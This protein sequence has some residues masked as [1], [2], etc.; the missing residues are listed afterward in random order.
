MN[1]SQRHIALSHLRR[2]EGYSDRAY[3]DTGGYWTVGYGHLTDDPDMTVDVQTAETLLQEDL[4]TAI[5]QAWSI[6]DRWNLAADTEVALAHMCFQLGYAG[7]TTF[8]K[9]L[10]ALANSDIATAIDEAWDSRWAQQT[11]Q[12]TAYVT[13]I[14]AGLS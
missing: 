1:S 5:S 7:T 9:M 6:I 3:S 13:G 2:A 4:S 12:R 11:P 8:K 10:A 14:L